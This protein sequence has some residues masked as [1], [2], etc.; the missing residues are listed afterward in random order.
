MIFFLVGLKIWFFTCPGKLKSSASASTVDTPLLIEA[1]VKKE[2]VRVLGFGITR[3]SHCMSLALQNGR[4]FLWEK[5]QQPCLLF[6]VVKF[7]L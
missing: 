7:P 3:I 5:R 2:R 4:S 6:L 1:E